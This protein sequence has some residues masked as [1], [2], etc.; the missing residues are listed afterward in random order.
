MRPSL[1]HPDP[2]YT[3][4]VEHYS[5]FITVPSEKLKFLRTT[6]SKYPNSPLADRVAWLKQLTFRKAILEELVQVLPADSPKPREVA[7]I[8]WLY[9]VRYP[10]FLTSTLTIAMVALVLGQWLYQN[11]RQTGIFSLRLESGEIIPKIVVVP[12]P[13]PV[14]TDKSSNSNTASNSDPIEGFALEDVWLVEKTAEFEQYSNGARILTKY[15]VETEPRNFFA[16]SRKAPKEKIPLPFDA[17]QAIF[18]PE[19]KTKP[20][21]ILYHVTQSDLLPFEPT[22]NSRLKGKS[23]H[24]IE[25]VKEE[26]LYNYVI[27]RFGQI[28]RV[29]KDDHYANHSGNSIWADEKAVYVRLNHSFI[30]VAF[31]GN[32]SSNIKLNPDDINEAQIYSCKL[33]TQILRNK[34]KIKATNCITHGQVSINPSD[35]LIGFHL[36]WA[37]GFPYTSCGLRDNYN[38]LP[39]SIT[40]FGFKYDRGFQNS[41][42]GKLWPGIELAEARL[43]ARAK[44]SEMTLEELRKQ[45]NKD[46]TLYLN[47]INK[48]RDLRKANSGN[49]EEETDKEKPLKLFGD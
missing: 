45:L 33:L 16:L 3:R 17:Q 21:G 14:S 35:Y 31:E 22:Y 25:Y 28:H 29:V 49:S 40:E 44:D 4:L 5:S 36:D 23:S 38:E 11:A 46:F 7:L 48:M 18:Y 8:Y 43:K 2:T 34:Y 39:P 27:D 26:K 9:R 47:W 15:E 37:I 10:V 12:S 1:E 41:I 20:V 13:V 24:L 19:E 42:G 6:L 32:W 30:G